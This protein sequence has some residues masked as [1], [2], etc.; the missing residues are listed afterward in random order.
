MSG[1][2]RDV[3]ILRRNKDHLRTFKIT[4]NVVDNKGILKFT[5]DKSATLTF[6]NETKTGK[7]LSFEVNNVFS[8]NCENPY[9]YTMTIETKEDVVETK[10]EEPK[11]EKI[12]VNS[13]A[14]EI[15]MLFSVAVML[16]SV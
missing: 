15:F 11:A 16:P 14:S 5:S 1:L 12:I 7:E 2:F 6:N 13:V 4:S 3:Y 8:W 10:I 9:L